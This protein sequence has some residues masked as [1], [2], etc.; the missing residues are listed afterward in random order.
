MAKAGLTYVFLAGVGNSEPDHWQSR[1]YRGLRRAIWLKHADWE[2]PSRDTW[3]VELEAALKTARGPKMV[4]AH[5]LGCLLLAE[6]ARDY[7]DAGLVAALLV[8]PPDVRGASFPERAPGWRQAFENPMPVPS[9]LV[10]SHDDPYASFGYSRR[11]AEHWG[12]RLVDAGD[13]GHINLKSELGDWDEGRRLL[14]ELVAAI[15]ED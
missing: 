7:A 4:M 14:E 3:V 12:A 9:V 6:W 8:A 10:A 1:W 13:R 11:L 5:S 2:C 15:E